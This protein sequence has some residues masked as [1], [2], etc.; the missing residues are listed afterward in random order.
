MEKIYVSSVQLYQVED[1]LQK[2]QTLFRICLALCLLV[3]VAAVFLFFYLKIYKILLE[4]TGIQRKRGML[5][6]QKGKEISMRTLM[7]TSRAKE[8]SEKLPL[9]QEETAVLQ[10]NISDEE[11]MVLEPQSVFTVEKELKLTGENL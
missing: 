6:L 4:V 1:Q 3:G 9:M 5:E 2:Y 11:T 7:K 10:G 8:E